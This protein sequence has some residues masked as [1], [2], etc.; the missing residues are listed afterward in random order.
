MSQAATEAPVRGAPSP[1]PSGGSGLTRKIGPLPV[2]GWVAAAA[3][4]G[5]GFIWWRNHQANAATA[6][7]S[8]TASG[9][10]TS[11][12]DAAS[13]A[14][15]QSEIQQLQGDESTDEKGKPPTDKEKTKEITVPRNETLAQL[16]RAEKWTKATLK[17]VEALNGLSPASKLRKGEK[18]K[19]PVAKT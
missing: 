16:A 11:T 8:D 14:T 7:T 6:A 19:R 4:V 1:S 9:V 12:D 5:V 13:I 2:W 3:A 10:D 17:A 18:I 15:L